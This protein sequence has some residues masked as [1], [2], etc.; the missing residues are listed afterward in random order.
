MI[1]LTEITATA[2]ELNQ[3][4]IAGKIEQNDLIPISA[5]HRHG[6][7]SDLFGMWVGS[8]VNYVVMVTGTLLIT[9]GLGLWES[10]AAILIG[11][12]LGC[13]IHGVL[14]L[15]GPR[16]GTSGIMISRTSFGQGGAFLPVIINTIMVFGWFLTN[17]VVATLGLEQVFTML[18]AP[19]SIASKIIA[20]LIVVIAEII[21][22][23]YGHATILKFEKIIAIVLA[24][25]FF[26]FLLF[27]LPNMN[28]N[29]VGTGSK[30]AGSFGN[31]L[32]GLAAII[33]YAVSWAN[34]AG[35]YSRYLPAKTDRKKVVLFAGVGLG[36]PLILIESVG[37]LFGVV[38]ENVCHSISASPVD[39]IKNIMPTWFTF[40]FMLFV[41]IGCL[42]TNVPN[43]YTTELSILALRVPIKRIKSVL[44]L[45]IG[46][47]IMSIVCLVFGQFYSWFSGFLSADAFWTC[48][49][50]AVVVVDYLMR[51]GNYNSIELLKWKTGEYWYKNGIL[52][53]GVFSFIVGIGCAM[54][55]MNSALFVSP[56][57]ALML[58]GGDISDFVGFL[59]AGVVFY[60][61]AHKNSSYARA[62]AMD[63]SI[64]PR[65]DSSMEAALRG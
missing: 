57:S 61:L 21:L 48:P 63:D 37:I 3:I 34:F 7:A 42:A 15:T 11:N 2:Q 30:T 59:V 9:L 6:K 45:T 29:Y 8:N 40:I 50:M 47:L 17:T 53:A 32:L 64:F 36:L 22:A 26:V 12:I 4:D 31:W 14:S 19:D 1:E 41:V 39:Q 23:M 27:L 38:L 60:L 10:F 62:R 20:L 46:V 16:S 65:D 28:W 51:K 55:F 13:F 43:G 49:W 35:D 25:V 18:G 52:W 24:A 58:G 44:F 56:L 33:A 5:E 54:L